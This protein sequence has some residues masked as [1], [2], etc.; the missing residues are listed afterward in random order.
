MVITRNNPEKGCFFVYV[1]CLSILIIC[2][3]YK[4]GYN[5]TYILYSISIED[6]CTMKFLR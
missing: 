5:K 2:F 4:K 1:K 3:F 6:D